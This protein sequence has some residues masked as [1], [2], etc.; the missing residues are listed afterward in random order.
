MH[1]VVELISEK[2]R[3]RRDLGACYE[4]IKELRR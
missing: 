4:V 1:K 3:E 2:I